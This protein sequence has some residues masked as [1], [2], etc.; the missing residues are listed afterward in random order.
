M[1]L[2]RESGKETEF[3]PVLDAKLIM[4]VVAAGIMSFCGVVVETAMNVAFPALMEEFSIDTAMVQWMTTGY[5]CVLAMV[6]PTSAWLKSRFKIKTLFVSSVLIFTSG[7]L[8]SAYTP[9]YALLLGGRILQG[10]GTGVALPLMFNIILDQT[11]YE[12]IGMMIGVGTLI[13]ALAPAVGPSLGG[14]IIES[15]GWREVFLCLIPVLF[16]SFC[17]GIFAIR[18][19]SKLSVKKFDLI[20][21]VELSVFILS[22]IFAL[23]EGTGYMT[24]SL[25]VILE[26]VVAVVSFVLFVRHS[27]KAEHPLLNLH[28]FANKTFSLAIVALMLLQ[29]VILA[30]GYLMPNYAQLVC[31]A[32]PADSGFVMLPGCL[33]GACLSPVSG[34]ILDRLGARKPITLGNISVLVSVVLLYSF[35]NTLSVSMLAGFYIFLTFGSSL[36]M[37]NTMTHS[38]N[39]LGEELKA[40]G[41]ALINTAQQLA[42]AIG[43]A[44]VT[45][46]VNA[47]QLAGGIN[48]EASRAGCTASFLSLVVLAAI[49]L[50]CTLCMFSTRKRPQR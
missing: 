39:H 45:G 2:E 36:T 10:V 49:M 11:P 38:L 20:G 34:H 12:N 32:G 28:V 43:T 22:S 4:S 14:I 35:S 47:Y 17:M 33:L 29:A 42:G 27:L 9:T 44:L 41:N 16:I 19:S 15:Y 25:S 8:L 23:S 24:L 21:F 30:L 31:L 46:I 48:V 26:I 6:I 40:D 37:G 1:S 7:V 3:V 5:L 50:L 18:Q 13:T